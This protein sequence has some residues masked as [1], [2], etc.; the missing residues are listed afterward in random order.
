MFTDS[1]LKLLQLQE[2]LMG[3][4]KDKRITTEILEAKRKY[5]EKLRLDPI[6]IKI[7]I[8]R[9]EIEELQ[10][11]M[12]KAFVEKLDSF[13]GCDSQAE[14]LLEEYKEICSFQKCQ[15]KMLSSKVDK[16]YKYFIEK[17]DIDSAETILKYRVG[18]LFEKSKYDKSKVEYLASLDTFMDT[19]EYCEETKYTYKDGEYLEDIIEIIKL[20]GRLDA[21]QEPAGCTDTYYSDKSKDIILS[22]VVG[23]Y[24]LLL[25][26]LYASVGFG[27]YEQDR[28]SLMKLHDICYQQEREKLSQLPTLNIDT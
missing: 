18:S 17:E 24:G 21:R 7:D 13:Q 6:E 19:P 12:I 25:Y 23:E 5:E 15:P 9:K 26:R 14:I 22:A 8:C 10:L 20:C 28:E 1:T 2:K 27:H 3:L 11:A 16:L 4:E